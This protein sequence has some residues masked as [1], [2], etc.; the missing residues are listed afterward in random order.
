[1]NCEE[2]GFVQIY[3]FKL[4]SLIQHLFSILIVF[5]W[6]LPVQHFVL[7]LSSSHTLQQLYSFHQLLQHR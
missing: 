4:A 6:I 2:I 7:S 3:K 1:M 5:T